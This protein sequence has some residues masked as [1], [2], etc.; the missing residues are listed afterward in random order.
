MRSIGAKNIRSIRTLTNGEMDKT[1]SHRDYHLIPLT[2]V[3]AKVAREIPVEWFEL[4][5]GAYNQIHNVIDE[6]IE[7]YLTKRGDI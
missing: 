7:K 2:E 1:H 5:E 6:E 4:W 3:R